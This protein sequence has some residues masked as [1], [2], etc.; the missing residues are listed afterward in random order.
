MSPSAAGTLWP[1]K[2]LSLRCLAKD[3]A[4]RLERECLVT[5]TA[6]VLPHGEKEN[7]SNSSHYENE[8][9]C[10]VNYSNAGEC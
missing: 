8:M 3:M 5:E 1:R 2:G 6:S 9:L 7:D 4:A 10:Q